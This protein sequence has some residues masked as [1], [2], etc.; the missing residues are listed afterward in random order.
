MAGVEPVARSARAL[1][2]PLPSPAPVKPDEKPS[3]TDRW[4]WLVPRFGRSE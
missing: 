2:R 4:K 3:S 1:P